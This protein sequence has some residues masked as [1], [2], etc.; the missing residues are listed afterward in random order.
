LAISSERVE[1]LREQQNAPARVLLDTGDYRCANIGDVAMLQVAVQRLREQIPQATIEVM[2]EDPGALALYC[3]DTRPVSCEGR[4]IWF[5]DRDLLGR[6]HRLLPRRMSNGVV[7]LKRLIRNRWPAVLAE[8]IAA[9]RRLRRSE[10]PEE[11]RRFLEAV[12]RAN[13]VAVT[14]AGGITDHAR[15]WSNQMFNLLELAISRGIPTVLFGHGLGPLT[16]PELLRRAERLLPQ[17]QLIALRERRFGV[18]ILRSL[19]VPNSRVFV[20]GDDAIEMAHAAT[21]QALG[22]GIGVN[23]RVSRS[24]D[25]EPGMVERV[26]RPLQDFAR[27]NK[28]PLVPIPIS[29]RGR[30]DT[31]AEDLSNGRVAAVASHFVLAP[32]GEDLSD[33]SAIA[34]LLAGYQ[35]PSEAGQRLDTP[36]KVIHQVGRCRIVVT[37]AYHAAVFALAQGIPAVCL[38][39]SRY[40]MDKF[41]GLA[42]QFG[43]GCEVVSLQRADCSSVLAEAMASTWV[44]A[45]EVRTPLLQAATRQIAASRAVY[46]LAAELVGAG[47]R[48][49]AANERVD[50]S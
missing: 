15:Q 14:G 43:T 42:G 20:T 32:G 11:H 27:E 26:R 6:I 2:T 4:R 50:L 31:G 10:G 18:E 12:F 36:Q 46:A 33:C 1:P 5:A 7:G 25:V 28:A 23:L 37:G 17:V 29:F 39:K 49:Q 48:H 9:K 30:F 34:R 22:C 45:E 40:F 16:N 38:A 8:I 35:D 41:L 19:Q 3:P 47:P 44:A 21:P 13:L 24:A